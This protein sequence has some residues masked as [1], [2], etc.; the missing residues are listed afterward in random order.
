MN[1]IRKELQ[2]YDEDSGV[3]CEYNN[4]GTTELLQQIE[5]QA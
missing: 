2:S 1:I 3:I 5:Q 4:E